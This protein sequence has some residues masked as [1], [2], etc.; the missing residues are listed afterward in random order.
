MI[1]HC[2]SYRLVSCHEVKHLQA[3]LLKTLHRELVCPSL[4]CMPPYYPRHKFNYDDDIVIVSEAMSKS[5]NFVLENMKAG[6]ISRKMLKN[7][8]VDENNKNNV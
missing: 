4:G 2:L 7:P 6:N 3:K 5:I 8:H 1:F